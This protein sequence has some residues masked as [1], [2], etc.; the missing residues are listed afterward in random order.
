MLMVNVSNHIRT[1]LNAIQGFIELLNDPGI[2][3]SSKRL[4]ISHIKTSSK[5]LLELVNNV[6]DITLLES[7]SLFIDQGECKL[8]ELM[9]EIHTKYSNIIR[10]KDKRDLAILLKTNI[11]DKEFTV[12]IDKKRLKQIIENLMENAI[13]F[14]DVGT[15]E[16][17]FNAHNDDRIEFFVKDNGSGISPE[18]LE[19]VFL[20]SSSVIDNKMA[21]FD[22]ASL[23]MSISKQLIRLMGGELQGK[24]EINVGSDFRFKLPIII[25]KL[26][27]TEMLGE[28]LKEVEEQKK[29]TPTRK[30]Q[31]ADK[32]ILIAEDVES[33]F[34]YLSE[35]LK[36]TGAKI[37]WAENGKIAYDMAITSSELDII[38]MDILMPEMDGYEATVK[39]KKELPHMP[40]IAQ[41]AYHLDENDYK[42][43]RLY[44][45]KI[46][47][48]PIWSYDLIAALKEF[49]N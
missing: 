31:W 10:E 1:P 22:L 20:K 49:L 26:I 32:T 30:L 29:E 25:E 4:Y 46:L 28:E 33:N 3:E 6:T 27:E 38:L 5:Y 18:R 11:V 37:L 9:S 36:E 19:M 15:I 41:T 16:F 23:R 48:K 39:I 45:N 40:I 44:F 21:P 34:I 7:K 43:A 2:N 17:G 42:D 35:I 47:I 14:T 24:S 13:T 8:N 12:K